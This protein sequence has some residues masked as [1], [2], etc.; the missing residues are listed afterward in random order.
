[1]AYQL[2][3]LERIANLLEILNQNIEDRSFGVFKTLNKFLNLGLSEQEGKVNRLEIEIDDDL[4]PDLRFDK[5]IIKSIPASVRSLEN[6]LIGLPNITRKHR[7][8]VPF[9]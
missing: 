7:D 9:V 6:Q 2:T 8:R 1:M 4:L 3:T 5:K